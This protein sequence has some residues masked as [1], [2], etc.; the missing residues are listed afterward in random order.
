MRSVHQIAG[1]FA[2]V[3]QCCLLQCLGAEE[4]QPQPQGLGVQKLRALLQASADP[5]RKL[6]ENRAR[7]DDPQYAALRTEIDRAAHQRDA[8]ASGLHWH[9]NLDEAKAEA[10]RSGRL[11]LSLRLLGK[12][13]EEYS[14]ANSRFFRTVLY[15]NQKVSRILSERYVLHWKSVRPAPL[16]T[17]DMGDGRRIKRT[18]TGNSIHYVLNS[19][20][21]VLDALPGIYSPDSFMLALKRVSDHALHRSPAEVRAWHGREAHALCLEWLSAAVEAGVYGD[22]AARATSLRTTAE[23]LLRSLATQ[24]F[25]QWKGTTKGPLW[26]ASAERRL[27]FALPESQEI[28]LPIPSDPFRVAAPPA[29]TIPVT[30]DFIYPAEFD[31]PKGMVERPVMK[32]ALPSPATAALDPASPAEPGPSLAGRMTAAIWAKLAVPYHDTVKLDEASRRLM[33]QKLPQDIVHLAEATAGA[34]ANGRTAFGRMLRRFEEAIAADMLRNEYYYHTQIHQWL[35][36]DREDRL[37]T[38]VEALNKRVYA[39]LFLTPD[40]DAWLGLVPEDAYTALEKD[41]CACDAG[42]APMRQAAQK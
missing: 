1:W 21:R 33:I 23:A 41:G 12:L 42:A 6:R 28:S 38:D 17:I 14:C 25:P 40:Y 4:Q 35:E 16:L 10:A 19:E 8:Y 36:E 15:A 11:I 29:G 9:T 2:A 22:T 34:P 27:R 32:K 39:E 30:R 5:I 13:D 7:L 20:G 24:A 26:V 3:L 37:A 31:P 18:I